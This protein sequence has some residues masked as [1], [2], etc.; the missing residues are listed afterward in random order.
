MRRLDATPAL[1]TLLVAESFAQEPSAPI[2][3]GPAA[4]SGGIVV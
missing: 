4:K 1:S 3:L 2:P